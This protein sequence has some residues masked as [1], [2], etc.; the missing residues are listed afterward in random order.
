MCGGTA[1]TCC[2]FASR[3]RRSGE[4]ACSDSVVAGEADLAAELLATELTT[5]ELTATELATAELAAT[6]LRIGNVPRS[7]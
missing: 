6:E 4:T 3:A 2:C 1:G 7:C 5:A